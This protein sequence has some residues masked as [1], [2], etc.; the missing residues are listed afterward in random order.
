MPSELPSLLESVEHDA[1]QGVTP[2]RELHALETRSSRQWAE[3]AQA[4][5]IGEM[6]GICEIG[7]KVAPLLEVWRT[8][9]LALGRDSASAFRQI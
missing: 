5:W 3:G 6:M 9:R 7:R 4:S 1:T 2:R 8:I